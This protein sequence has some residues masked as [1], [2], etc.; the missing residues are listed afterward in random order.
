MESDPA[1]YRDLSSLVRRPTEFWPSRDQTS[2]ERLN[3]L[4]RL[5]AYAT[6]AVFLYRKNF[7]YVAFGMGAVLVLSVVHARGSSRE[8]I[9]C[10]GPR[11][12]RVSTA[13]IKPASVQRAKQACTR[14]TPNN[15]FGNMLVSDLADN[16]GRPP[17]CK[18]D[19][20]A[21]A[22]QQNFNRGLPRNMYD[23]YDRE[24]SQRQFVTMPVTT[25]A[26]DT[27]AF[28][29]FCYGGAGRKTCKEDPSRCTGSF[30]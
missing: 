24:N 2:D 15:P 14:S 30:P 28:A 13:N 3:S 8:S 18:F 9:Q 23:L 6:L 10:S 5:L 17:A 11:S 7:K 19:D 21:E 25:S 12:C 27:V 16:P 29:Q 1:W 4:V 22:V 26:P 20:Q